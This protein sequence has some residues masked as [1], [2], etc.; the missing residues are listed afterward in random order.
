LIVAFIAR[1]GGT[2]IVTLHTSVD[3]CSANHVVDVRAA[4]NGANDPDL[5]DA[6]GWTPTLYGVFDQS[7]RVPGRVESGAVRSTGRVPVDRHSAASVHSTLQRQCK[8][9]L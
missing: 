2:A 9:T 8:S 6:V 7:H 4:Y 1:F 3:A 5:S